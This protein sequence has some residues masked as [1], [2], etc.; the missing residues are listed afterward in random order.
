MVVLMLERIFKKYREVKA[1]QPDTLLLFRVG[2]FY[3]L[4]FDDAKTAAKVVGLTL[5][6]RNK[7]AAD[8]VPMTGFPYHHLDVYVKK[9]VHA[10]HR[11]F[12]IE[13]VS[14]LKAVRK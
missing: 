9:L 7:A 8:P 5:T 13:Q 11:C 10:G 4:Y 14:D 12:V 1:E 6:T 3:E 2:D